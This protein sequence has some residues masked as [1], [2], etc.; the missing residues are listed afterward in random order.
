MSISKLNFISIAYIPYSKSLNAASDRRRFL[1]FANE[2]KLN[3]ELYDPNKK[4]DLVIANS[5]SDPELLLNLPS[6]TKLIFDFA[7]AY[8]AENTI[9]FRGLLRGLYKYSKGFSSKFYFNYKNAFIDIMRRSEV[10]ICSSL[11][12]KKLIMPFCKNIKIILDSHINECTKVKKNFQVGKIINIGWEGQHVTLPSLLSLVKKISNT[13]LA[14]YVNYHVVT[15]DNIKNS[16]KLFYGNSMSRYLSKTKLPISFYP[17]NV[18]NMN[19]L[20][21]ICDFAVVPVDLNN[22]IHKMKPENR[23]HL[24]WRLGLPV[25]AS[26]SDSNVRAMK[27]C[28]HD[29]YAKS[30]FEWIKIIESLRN[31]PEKIHKYSQTALKYINLKF[32]SKYYVDLWTEALM[33]CL[34]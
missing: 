18:E 16:D 1:F 21:D 26:S 13:E 17:W 23:I 28:N 14:S 22:P 7:D 20:S 27:M 9:S 29:L 5:L 25:L 15:D 6:K 2:A 3:Y 24:F 8:M 11:E 12:Q 4:Y 32:T 31:Y 33:S 30:F 34:N 10:V 19:N